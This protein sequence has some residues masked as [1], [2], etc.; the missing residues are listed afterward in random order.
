MHVT[1]FV[2]PYRYLLEKSRVTFNKVIPWR[3]QSTTHPHTLTHTH[4]HTHTRARTPISTLTL[5][6]QGTNER[7]YH[8][9][10]HMLVL[11]SEESKA[12]GDPL[13]LTSKTAADFR[14]EGR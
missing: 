5:T 7:N 9:F 12:F 1:I 10:Y 8:V 3:T 6:P 11:A 4:T 13:F 2:S 14:S